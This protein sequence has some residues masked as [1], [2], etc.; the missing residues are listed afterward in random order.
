ML[1]QRRVR[2]NSQNGNTSKSIPLIPYRHLS[3][4]FWH[5]LCDTL[6][7]RSSK[8]MK[9]FPI[10]SKK[11]FSSVFGRPPA[12]SSNPTTLTTIN[13][14]RPSLYDLHS[15][16]VLFR[17]SAGVS[18][19]LPPTSAEFTRQ[20]FINSLL[21]Q[22][23][24]YESRRAHIISV[25]QGIDLQDRFH[26]EVELLSSLAIPATPG[27]LRSNPFVQLQGHGVKP[28]VPIFDSSALANS[29]SPF[30]GWTSLHQGLHASLFPI[31]SGHYRTTNII[32]S[33]LGEKSLPG[34]T[35]VTANTTT[36]QPGRKASFPRKL[37]GM[38]TDLGFKGSD[39]AAFLPNGQAFII[40]KP[41][42]FTE[43]ILPKYFNMHHFASFQ[44]QLNLYKFKR[45][46]KD[47]PYKGAYYHELFAR[48]RHDLIP[49]IKR[50]QTTKLIPPSSSKKQSLRKAEKPGA[51][52][53]SSVE[54]PT[55]TSSSP[56]LV[57]KVDK[58]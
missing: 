27:R 14:I 6:K 56:N 32:R 49:M 15:G 31:I 16:A 7:N 3:S 54:K 38:L 51:V 42:E 40:F 29:R 36:N 47:G 58:L 39:I 37:L 28:S 11:E 24:H 57:T 8:T 52:G 10:S 25:L 19:P 5:I 12:F 44:R 18:K 13:N 21:E 50:Q 4:A 30:Q 2:S 35:D 1:L 34:S 41:N 53:F 26:E 22:Q 20:I 17:S 55:F 33:E 45:T 23:Q 9:S 43:E 46:S 48:E